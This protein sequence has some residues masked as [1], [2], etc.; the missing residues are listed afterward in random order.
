MPVIR[1]GLFLACRRMVSLFSFFGAV[2]VL[3]CSVGC[4]ENADETV[5]ATA[6]PAKPA[7]ADSAITAS[8]SAAGTVTKSAD[9]RVPLS[10]DPK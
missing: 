3:F 10:G 4:N 9:T 1:P 7:A 6:P 5:G 2:A 8:P